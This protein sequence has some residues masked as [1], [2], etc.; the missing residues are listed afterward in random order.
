LTTGA[1]TPDNPSTTMIADPKLSTAVGSSAPRTE[2]LEK[3]TGQARYLDDLT[4]PGM[5]HGATIRSTLPRGRLRSIHFGPGAPWDEIVVVTARDIPGKNVVTLIAEDQ[6]FLVEQ[7]IRHREEPVVL[8]AHPDREVLEAARRAIR[9]EVEPLPAVLD[10]G[11]ADQVMKA[12]DLRKGDVDSVWATADRVVEGVYETGAQEQLYIEPQGVLAEWSEEGLSVWGSLQCP[13][14]VHKALKPLFGLS[15]RQVRVVQTTTGGGFGGKEEYPSLI[16][17]HAALLA[18]KAGR[19]VKLVY[20][21]AEDMAATTKRHPSRTRHRTAVSR[22]GRLLA[23]D[24]DFAI[25]AG[26]YLTLSPVVL[27]RGAIHAAGPYRCEHVRVQARALQTNHPPHGAFRGFGAPQSIFALER[28]L[29]RVAG[30]LGMPPEELR[31]RNLLRKGETTAT[32]QRIEEDIDLGGLLDQA[33]E[34]SRYPERRAAC[35]AHNASGGQ[36]RRGIGLATFFHGSG[37]T[38]SGEVH[39]ASVAHVRANH[40]GQIDVLASSTEIGQGTNTIFTQI[41]SQ[42]L[43]IPATWVRVVPPDTSLVPDS[44]PTVAS[45]TVM[46]VG[47]LVE[48]ACQDLLR[49]LAHDSGGPPVDPEGFRSACAAFLERN[50][51]AGPGPPAPP[52]PPRARRG[53]ARYEPPPGVVWDDQRYQGAAYGCYGWA[54]YV[55]EVE[56]DL[57]TYEARVT[58]FVAVQD[59]GRVLNPAL[60]AGQVEGGVAQGI[61]FA[62]YE[63]VVWR[64][65]VMANNRMT[66][67]I[68]P[69]SADLPPIRVTF[70]EVPYA[71]GPFGAKGV[72][73]LPM[74]GP[75]P[76]ILNAICHA[77][78]LELTRIPA[79]PERIFEAASGGARG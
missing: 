54:A 30:R 14:Y 20:D 19:P 36:T 29:D 59:V 16:A 32:G 74:D 21:R 12:I 25:D 35:E 5:L 15:D 2:G 1:S 70:T 63:E 57:V 45:R 39:L 79:L 23:M 66:N 34:Q 64:D 43:G 9:L 33:L 44:G 78:G 27:S 48:R 31:R 47:R 50:G 56:L 55:A 6:P 18:K 38:G 7:E 71:Y 76:A 60:A 52:A 61:G 28:H 65:G 69:T 51:A 41:A 13:Y 4:R 11:I 58:D 72:G 75:A 68:M 3:A 67:Y 24:I 40:E 10:L 73:E 46:V 17:G 37:F 22:D 53:E 8:I 77:T 49:Q 42:T 62:L 26:A